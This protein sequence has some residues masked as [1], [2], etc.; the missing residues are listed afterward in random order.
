MS[1]RPPRNLAGAVFADLR[2][3]RSPHR[4][5]NRLLQ[6][7]T[8]ERFL[9]RLSMSSEADRFTLKGATLFLAWGGVALRGTRD[10]DLVRSAYVSTDALRRILEAVCME[11]CLNDGVVFSPESITISGASPDPGRAGSPARVKLTGSLHTARLSLQVDIGFGDVITPERQRLEFPT[12]LD[13]PRPE[14][15][16]YPRETVVAEKLHAMALFGQRHSRIK[17]V[18]DVAALAAHFPFHGPTLRRAVDRTFHHRGSTPTSDL[19]A[20]FR[21]SFYG[22]ESQSRWSSFHRGTTVLASQPATLS[23][24]ARMLRVFLEPVWRSAVR[25]EP[26]DSSWAPGGPWVKPTEAASGRVL[27]G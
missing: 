4:D 15:W 22:D 1:D 26:F 9:Y 14:L 7:F 24:A 6:Q 23:D 20:P 3:L 16:T 5:F 25:Q 8:A 17:D 27:N 18:W 11:P 12:L 2:R 13:H 10:V 19:P 21:A